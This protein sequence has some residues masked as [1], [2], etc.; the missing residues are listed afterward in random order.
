MQ[1]TERQDANVAC[2][3]KIQ[4]PNVMIIREASRSPR[5]NNTTTRLKSFSYRRNM[6]CSKKAAVVVTG[7]RR[8][9]T[10][11]PQLKYEPGRKNKSVASGDRQPAIYWSIF[12]AASDA[13]GGGT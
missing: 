8:V 11:H 6:S 3:I 10:P 5:A 9:L 12:Q 4:T 13:V 7:S 2:F 1:R